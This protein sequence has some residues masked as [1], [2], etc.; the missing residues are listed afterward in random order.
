M[1]RLLALSAVLLL[2]ALGR[3]SAEDEPRVSARLAP[4][5]IGTEQ[6][7]R[8]IIEVSGSG[9]GSR[10]F[11]PDFELENLVI[12]SGPSQSQSFS[13][14]N[15]VASRS[16]SLSWILRPVGPGAARVHSIRVQYGDTLYEPPDL[17]LVVE[18][19]AVVGS[20]QGQRQADPFEDF[21]PSL[22]G[23]L[24]RGSTPQ[25]EVFLR[26]ELSPRSP[27]VGQQVV[28]TLYLYTQAHVA[29]INPEQLPDFAGF[30]VRDI[31]LGETPEVEMVDVDGRRFGRVPILRRALFPLRSGELSLESAKVQLSVRMPDRTFGSMFSDIESIRR[32]SNPLSLT[33]RE[34][35]PDAPEGFAGAVGSL[36]IE[37]HL[38]PTSVTVG[39]AATFKVT[40]AGA[41][42]LQGL[43]APELPEMEGVRLFPPQQESGERVV[44]DQVRG[45]RS[46]NFILVPEVAAPLELPPIEI[47]YF[48]PVASAY[49]TTRS[50]P[51]TLAVAPAPVTEAALEPA[52]AAPIDDA[53]AGTDQ[54]AAAAG[55][56][57]TAILPWALVALL[58]L[59]LIVALTRRRPGSGAA[60]PG[61]AG[62]RSRSPGPSPSPGQGPTV[63]AKERRTL[64]RDFDSAVEAAAME[65]KPRATAH[66]IEEAWRS[67][68]AERWEIEPSAPTK[69]WGERLEGAGADVDEVRRLMGLVDD[70]HYLR[71]APQLADTE[72]LAR[73]LILRS[74]K[75]QRSLQ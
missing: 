3:A 19:E 36:E 13:F 55:L 12:D 69:Q 65:A 28:Y 7:T 64:N 67:W 8:L 68:L 41:G 49:R 54:Q 58:S 42:H 66:A 62:Q 10:Q 14:T 26:A 33:A 56:R 32:D 5:R 63:R 20:S 17:Q 57:W 53:D 50:E 25:P 48:D 35:P 30:W 74:Q 73:E 61:S 70:L 6:L 2:A 45:E 39:E 52:A 18:N 37:A 24:R 43:P 1:R 11:T 27:W 47:S 75:I 46:W 44:G 72:S 31:D 51:L 40:L 34:L 9:I 21:F 60:R 59:A 29:S 23:R 71:Y 38:E 15:G 22:R 16:Q 4:E